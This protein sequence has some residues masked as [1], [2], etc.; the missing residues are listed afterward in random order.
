MLYLWKANYFCLCLGR[1]L[2]F[3][4]K[5][6]ESLECFNKVLIL[7]PENVEAI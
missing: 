1:A 5:Y 3:I 6:E 2:S 7:N 4:G